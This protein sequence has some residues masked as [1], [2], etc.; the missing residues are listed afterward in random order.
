MLSYFTNVTCQKYASPPH[1]NPHLFVLITDYLS[2][3]PIF[4]NKLTFSRSSQTLVLTTPFRDSLLHL[5]LFEIPSSIV[6]LYFFPATDCNV[7][8]FPPPPPS[9]LNKEIV[10]WINLVCLSDI[11]VC[12]CL[13]LPQPIW[14][15]EV[16]C[17]LRCIPSA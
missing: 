6:T 1:H 5:G 14:Y 16:S 2:K 15:L 11:P 12:L 13:E 4:V 17:F 9:Q 8:F 10:V 3:W 7:V